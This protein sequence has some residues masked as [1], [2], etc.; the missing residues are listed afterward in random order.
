M[1]N[2]TKF[3]AAGLIA[4][5]LMFA[6]V[7]ASAHERI[8]DAAMGAAAGALVAGPIG[9]VAGGAIGYVEGPHIS[10]HIFHDHHHY[11]HYRRHRHHDYR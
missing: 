7:M 10:H 11:R 6:P 1:K 2:G 9:L 5:S 4:A 8:G 3:V